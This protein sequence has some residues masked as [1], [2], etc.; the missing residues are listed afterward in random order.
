MN[1]WPHVQ[2]FHGEGVVSAI[3]ADSFIGKENILR[4]V[5]SF[6]F[7]HQSP[8]IEEKRKR[9]RRKKNKCRR[10][11]KKEKLESAEG[12]KIRFVLFISF[13]F[14]GLS[15]FWNCI[16]GFGVRMRDKKTKF[17]KENGTTLLLF[18]IFS[19]IS[20]TCETRTQLSNSGGLAAVR[21]V[22]CVIC[23]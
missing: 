15:V 10:M 9:Q 22:Y 20:L 18:L 7:V 12:V 14:C 13:L 16:F 5:I 19:S 11:E 21:T 6:G 3:L 1:A 8:V 17:N 23:V 2:L 4:L